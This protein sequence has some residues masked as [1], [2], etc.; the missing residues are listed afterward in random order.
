MNLITPN[1]GDNRK[2]S[3]P[4]KFKQEFLGRLLFK[5]RVLVVAFASRERDT[6]AGTAYK[7]VSGHNQK[8]A[9]FG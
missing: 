4:I 9:I 6:L 5:V 1:S 3:Y 8:I 2:S 7:P